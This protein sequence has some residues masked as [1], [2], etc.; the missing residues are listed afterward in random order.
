MSK[1]LLEVLQTNEKDFLIGLNIPYKNKDFR[2]L[3][4]CSK[5]FWTKYINKNK[6]KIGTIINKNKKYYSSTISRFYIRYKKRKNI[7]KYIAKLKTIWNSK[8]IL[9]IEGEKSRV[10]IG[11]DLFDNAKSIK[12][13]VCPSINAFSVYD[14]II[15]NVIM[16]NEKRLILIALGPTASILAYDLFKL[17]YQSIDIGHL[18]IEYE[19]FLRNCTSKIPIENK[20]VNEAKGTKYISKKVDDSKYLSQIIKIIK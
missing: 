20:Y 19:W 15:K 13:I 7:H 1:R 4:D 6:F 5:N 11:N 8:H 16:Y 3:K 2:M 10:G 18:D 14:K 12:R 17:G 9:I